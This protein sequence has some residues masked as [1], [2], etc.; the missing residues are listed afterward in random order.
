LDGCAATEL[1]VAE[2]PATKV[3]ALTGERDP[4]AVTRMLVAGA[5]GFAVKGS[6]PTQLADIVVRVARDGRYVD[7]AAIDGLVT[8]VVEMAR[9]E[10]RRRAHA[11][12]LADELRRAYRE[13][14]SALSAALRTRDGATDEHVDRVA[15]RVVAVAQRLGLTGQRLIDVEYGALFH[16]IG[17][18]GIP[19]AILHNTDDLTDD[20]WA[21]IR[22]H[23]IIGEQ[24]IGTVGFLKPVARIVRHSHEHWDGS[25]YPDGLAGEAIPIESR[26][27]LVCDAYDAMTSWR[28]YQQTM[29]PAE[30]VARLHELRGTRFDPATVDALCEVLATQHPALAA[31][32]GDPER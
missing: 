14:I 10:R 1:V 6:D 27:I 30:A 9:S 24:I 11:E 12:R 29:T 22:E 4:E 23:T 17:K 8:S 32:A 16:D 26:I 15:A 18:I 28:S 5:S 13:T 19:D 7:V 31:A 20:E 2:R 25:G 21:V 3:I